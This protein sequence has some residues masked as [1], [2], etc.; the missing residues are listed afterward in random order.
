MRIFQAKM[1]H[2]SHSPCLL[3]NCCVTADTSTFFVKTWKAT[4]RQHFTVQM[5]VGH[6]DAQE[7]Q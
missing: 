7:L 3:L 4:Q 1:R 6:M 2:K 5:E